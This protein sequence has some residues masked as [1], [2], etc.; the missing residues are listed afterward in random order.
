MSINLLC[1]R[2]KRTHKLGTSK[3]S[4]GAGL[5]YKRKY[6]VRVKTAKGWKS[7]TVDTLQDAKKLEGQLIQDNPPTP[8]LTPRQELGDSPTLSEVWPHY[9]AWAKIHKKSWNMDE[10]RYRIYLKES[11][12]HLPMDSIKPYQVQSILNKMHPEF[13]PSTITKVLMLAKRLYSWSIEQG[14]YEGKNPCAVIKAPRYDNRVT[15]T[16]SQNQLERLLKVLDDWPNKIPT[17]IIRFALYSGK[18]KGEILNLQWSDI[19]LQNGFITLRETKSGPMQKA[20][21]NKHCL[22]II[23]SASSLKKDSPYVFPSR[24]GTRY[25]YGGI[26]KTWRLIR[27]KADLGKFRFHDLRHTYASYLASSGK[28]DIYTLKELL[29]HSDIKM[30]MRYAHLINGALKKA[31]CVAD[32]VFK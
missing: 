16:L 10:S 18:R 9:L 32:E 20:P 27:K 31:A 30:T 4:C 29:G 1:H 21:L 22:E 2:C 14:L 5:K 28:V 11:L 24:T 25:Y 17:L 19:D 7:G 23:Q 6:R 3:C 12:G 15:N 13:K 26:D 8:R